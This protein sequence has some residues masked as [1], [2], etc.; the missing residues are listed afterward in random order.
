MN[1]QQIVDA[2]NGLDENAKAELTAKL[3]AS[4]EKPLHQIKTLRA[5]RSN[6]TN[7]KTIAYMTATADRLGVTCI[8]EDQVVDVPTLN[9]Q[10]RRSGDI[11]SRM[12]L[13]SML[14]ELGMIPA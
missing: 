12:S 7:Q 11:S 1:V 2:I 13:K 8:K 9:E 4:A 10:L 5:A 3:S 14:F 6:P